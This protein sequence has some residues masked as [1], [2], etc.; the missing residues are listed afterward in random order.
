[1]CE[2]HTEWG[3]KCINSTVVNIFSNNEQFIENGDIRKD[4]VITFKQRHEGLMIFQIIYICGV[5]FM[6]YITTLFSPKFFNFPW[7]DSWL[8]AVPR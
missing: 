8:K 6:E 5:K 7:K 3:I 4:E 2:S 1:M